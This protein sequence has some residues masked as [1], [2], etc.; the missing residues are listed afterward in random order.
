MSWESAKR[1]IGLYARRREVGGFGTG[2]SKPTRFPNQPEP[3]QARVQMVT[4]TVT[5]FSQGSVSP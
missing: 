4:Q 2:S 3:G 5:Q 1:D